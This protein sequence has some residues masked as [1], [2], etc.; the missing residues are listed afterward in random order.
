MANILYQKLE[1][2]YSDDGGNT[3]IS[4]NVYKVGNVIENPSDC[5]ADLSTCR[6]RLLDAS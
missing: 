6:W 3:W 2:Q 1:R 5:K 4:M